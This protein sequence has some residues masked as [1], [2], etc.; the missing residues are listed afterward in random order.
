LHPTA[1]ALL[2]ERI[3][4]RAHR[5]FKTELSQ[6]YQRALSLLLSDDVRPFDGDESI[7]LALQFLLASI[8]HL[9]CAHYEAVASLQKL[10]ASKFGA[11]L[12]AALD[13]SAHV[14]EV[15]GGDFRERCDQEPGGGAADPAK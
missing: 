2:E 5:I 11:L 13:L 7:D 6:R 4:E 10:V 12:D 1:K 9:Q 8:V 15:H 3:R 14:V